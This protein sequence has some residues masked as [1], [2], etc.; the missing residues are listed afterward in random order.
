MRLKKILKFSYVH[1]PERLKY[2]SNVFRDLLNEIKI[3]GHSDL[4]RQEFCCDHLWKR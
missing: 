3:H 4:I 1:I 2:D